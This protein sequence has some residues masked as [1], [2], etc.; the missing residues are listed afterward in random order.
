M[1]QRKINELETYSKNKN[2][3]NHIGESITLRRVTNLINI[4]KNEKGNLVA[5]CHNVLSRWSNNLSQLMDVNGDNEVRWKEIHI[6]EPI[7]VS[8]VPLRSRWLLKS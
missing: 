3:T 8:P 7:C 2:I 4:A 6:G 5:D 1:E